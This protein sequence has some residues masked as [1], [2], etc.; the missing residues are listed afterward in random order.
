MDKTKELLSKLLSIKANE[1]LERQ[2]KEGQKDLNESVDTD[3]EENPIKDI[4]NERWNPEWD[5]LDWESARNIVESYAEESGDLKRK[6]TQS[7]EKILGRDIIN[8]L[9]QVKVDLLKKD[10]RR[11][12]LFVNWM[13]IIDS[14]QL[15]GFLDQ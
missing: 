11:V 6:Y 3:K 15:E 4:L 5:D 12:S 7:V 2:E 8:E 14:T 9:N 13:D 1:E 10:L